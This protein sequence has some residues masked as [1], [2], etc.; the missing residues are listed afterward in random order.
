MTGNAGHFFYSID[1]NAFYR[2]GFYDPSQNLSVPYNDKLKLYTLPFQ[3][4]TTFSDNYTCVAGT[5]STYSAIV[6]DGTYVSDVDGNGILRVPTG[7]F[8]NVFRIYY[9]ESFTLKA[10]I[11]LGSYMGMVSITEFGYEFWKSGHVKPLLTYYNTTTT[12]LIGG[13]N[14]VSVGVRY[15]KHAPVDGPNTV[16]VNSVNQENMIHLGLVS[17]KVF[18]VNS[19]GT[20]QN[21]NVEVYDML[22]KNVFSSKIN[23]NTNK[24]VISLENLTSGLYIININGQS[25]NFNKKVALN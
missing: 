24:Y 23:D 19:I 17:P 25:I 20:L 4:G 14:T 11:G 10:D 3:F 22:G 16:S 21:C 13:G 6:D 9:E 15:D 18:Y 5:F 2:D 1:A 7:Y 12:D 8:N